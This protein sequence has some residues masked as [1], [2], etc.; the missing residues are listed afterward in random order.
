MNFIASI[1]WYISNLWLFLQF[2][3]FKMQIWGA[4][5]A[6]V[7]VFHLL[8]LFVQML[9]PMS[10][11]ILSTPLKKLTEQLSLMYSTKPFLVSL[12]AILVF[13]CSLQQLS[14][15]VFTIVASIIRE[16]FKEGNVRVGS[17]VLLAMLMFEINCCLLLG[18]VA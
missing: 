13:W 15:L 14:H 18:V 8:H 10:F 11:G 2:Q 5:A 7:H 6:L 4:A 17:F 1:W 12:E 16:R 3:A 9:L